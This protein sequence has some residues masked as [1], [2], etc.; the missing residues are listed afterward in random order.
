MPGAKVPVGFETLTRAI[1]KKFGMMT[2][3]GKIVFGM[4]RQANGK[5][6]DGS[7]DSRADNRLD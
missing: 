5:P 6:A 2:P 7:P 4:S 1:G 3:N